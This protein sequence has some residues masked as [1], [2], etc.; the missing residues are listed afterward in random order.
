MIQSLVNDSHPVSPT[1]PG[2]RGRPLPR[3]PPT[4]E[5]PSGAADPSATPGEFLGLR[6]VSGNTGLKLVGEGAVSIV[7]SLSLFRF[8]K[9][10]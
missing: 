2:Q 10:I 4:S 6:V 5:S 9:L 7:S 3:L 1:Q 8:G